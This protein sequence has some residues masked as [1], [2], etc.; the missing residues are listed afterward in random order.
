LRVK[1]TDR[2]AAMAANLG[3]AG[4]EVIETADGMEIIGRECLQGC[5]AESRGDHRIAMSML[6]AG[7]AASGPVTVHDVECI[8][9]SFPDF[10][11]LL[12]KVVSR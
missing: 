9:T 8:A 11:E 10:G 12:E 4:V 5:V 3:K 6:I 7:L 2:I 1:E